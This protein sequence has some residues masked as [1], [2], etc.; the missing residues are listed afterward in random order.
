MIS[1]VN[2]NGKGVANKNINRKVT[3]KGN[4]TANGNLIMD[5]NS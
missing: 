2:M 4:V 3:E 5:V 1:D